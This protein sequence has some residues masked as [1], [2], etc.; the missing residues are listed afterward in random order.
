ML[1]EA[2][3]GAG[4]WG[5][6]NPAWPLP[7]GVER[8]MDTHLAF[9]TLVYAISGGREPGSLWAAARKTYAADPTLF[10]PKRLAYE[11]AADLQ[12]PLN[13]Y[14]LTRKK[15]AA[16]AVWQ[17]IGQALVM[18]GGGSVKNLLADNTYDALKLLAMLNRS[19]T[20]FPVLSGE[21]TAPRWLHGLANV[22]RQPLTQVDALTVPVSPAADLAL[23]GLEIEAKQVSAAIFGPLDALGR[24]GCRQRPTG[25]IICPAAP[26]CPVAEF[27]QYGR[28]AKAN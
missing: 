24:L 17:R 13:Q 4:L 9:L 15:A 18:R 27:C 8:G 25:E 22:G 1:I 19:K 23:K 26:D 21:Q 16:A 28:I 11:K 10:D 7:E 2:Y 6:S 14:G 20:I 5:E 3:A 12:A